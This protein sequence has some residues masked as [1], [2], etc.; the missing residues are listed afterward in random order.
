MRSLMDL[1]F[2]P[3][4]L[5]SKVLSLP[6][7]PHP[8]FGEG[9]RHNLKQLASG[10]ELRLV[11][12]ARHI[13]LEDE[14][15]DLIVTSPPYWNKRDYGHPDQIGQERTPQEFVRN[16]VLAMAEWRRVLKPSGSIFLNIGDT[17]HNRSLVGVPGRLEAAAA[18]DKW[19]L[20]NRIIWA[21][22]SGMPEPAKNRLANRHEY[23]FHWTKSH[24]YYYDLIGYSEK[25]GNG[26]NPGDVW[27]I[28]LRR[29]TSNHLAPFPEELVERAITLACPNEICP[30]CG[31]ARTRIFQRTAK[32]DPSRP[33]ARRAMELAKAAKLTPLHIAAIQS[34]GISDA[35]KALRVQTGTGKNAAN[36]QKLAAEAKAVLGGYF[37]EFTF[38]KKET[39]GWTKCGCHKA[40]QPAVVLDP[41]AG[42]GTTLRVASAMGRIG[43]GIDLASDEIFR[44]N[45]VPEDHHAREKVPTER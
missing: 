26:S 21:K 2:V 33:Q 17:Y 28:S 9:H 14:S 25:Y 18:D 3:V 11:G 12:D 35:G 29:D 45:L 1:D 40:F 24:N 20:R 37:R 31:H 15:V 39:V 4:P 7:S 38:A 34:T 41:F 32:L 10:S 43:V 6:S 42:T 8:T 13:P 23:I 36:V 30:Q 5:P 16:I 27:N 22:E 44:D 19:I